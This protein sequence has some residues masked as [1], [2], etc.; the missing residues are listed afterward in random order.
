MHIKNA[1]AHGEPDGCGRNAAIKRPCATRRTVIEEV[2]WE[3][4]RL[5]ELGAIPPAAND[6]VGVETLVPPLAN[7]P[8]VAVGRRMRKLSPCFGNYR[9]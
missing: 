2:T 8:A 7:H 4:F 5:S 9:R 6:Q 3:S 1:A